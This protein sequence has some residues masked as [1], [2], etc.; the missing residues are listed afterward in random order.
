MGLWFQDSVISWAE[1][2]L[3]HLLKSASVSPVS[4]LDP[5]ENLFFLLTHPASVFR[6]VSRALACC[7][8]I[9]QQRAEVRADHLDCCREIV[10]PWCACLGKCASTSITELESGVTLTGGWIAH[11]IQL[12]QTVQAVGREHILGK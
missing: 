5:V 6:L 9:C 4:V 12:K 3:K 7:S 10:F 11:N 2:P 1:V 8:C